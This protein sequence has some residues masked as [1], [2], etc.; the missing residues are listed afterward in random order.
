MASKPQSPT[1]RTV[2]APQHSPPPTERELRVQAVHR[3]QVGLF[4]L[5]AVL[6]IIGLA[7]I[8]MDRALLAEVEN[9]ALAPAAEAVAEPA[10]DPL[11]DLGVAPA[12]DPTAAAARA[13]APR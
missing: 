7:N 6:L 5:C 11:A 4:G 12:T 1:A 13:T 3:L 8:I 10:V 9:P 2:A